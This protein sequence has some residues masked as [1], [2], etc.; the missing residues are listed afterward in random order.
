MQ[1]EVQML[2]L[3]QYVWG[4]CGGSTCSH[5][6]RSSR[7]RRLRT[8]AGAFRVRWPRL[9]ARSAATGGAPEQLQ[10]PPQRRGGGPHRRP[11]EGSRRRRWTPSPQQTTNDLSADTR[12]RSHPRPTE[13]TGCDDRLPHCSDC[14]PI[15]ATP[16]FRKNY[17]YR[18]HC[19]PASFTVHVSLSMVSDFR[20]AAS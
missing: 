15:L 3:A 9:D 18:S 5:A 11:G 12:L 4:R 16:N 13:L 1:S 17:C 19:A 6:P 14:R 10:R 7:I 8:V 2:R 20:S